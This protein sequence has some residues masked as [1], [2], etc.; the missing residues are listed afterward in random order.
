MHH[1]SLFSLLAPVILVLAGG[2]AVLGAE[3]FLRRADKHA[4]L[5]WIGAI[6]AAI[7]IAVQFA[8]PTGHVHG[9]YAMDPARLWLC[10]S[11]V[12]AGAL[13]L[14]GLQQTLAR[15]DYHGGEPYALTLFATAGAMLMVM[16]SDLL[17]LFVGLEIASLSVYALV[18]LRRQRKESNE[19]LFKYFALGAVFSAVFLY[20]AALIYGA[21]GHTGLGYAPLPERESLWYLGHGLLVLALLF[22]V[23]VVPFHTWSPD[24]YTGAPAAVTGFMGAVIKVG[25]FTALGAVWLHLLAVSG[26]H[27]SATLL[28][29]DQAVNLTQVDPGVARF[30]LVFLVLA[31]VSVIIGNFS[32]LRQSSARRMMAYS[33][34]AHAGYMLFA[35]VLPAA[36][37]DGPVNIHLGGLWFYLV[38]YGLATAGALTAIAALAGKDDAG[39]ELHGLSGQ[40]RA[41]PFH[42]LMLTVFVASFAGIPPTVGFVG[43]F[44]VFS[45]LVVGDHILV[46]VVAMILAVVAAAYY[47]RLLIAVWAPAGREP[48]VAG[49]QLLTGWTTGLAAAAVVALIAIAGTFSA[50]AA[51][52]VAAAAVE[53]TP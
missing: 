27:H 9:L 35:L 40:G 37:T 44:L 12:A 52:P 2:L 36:A 38:G 24:A 7:A 4:W 14:A 21:T 53:A 50:P 1:V 22:K 43:K 29:L 13:G 19:G 15:D 3:P 18:G 31:L 32:A 17:A 49:P 23:G 33:S 6:F 20:G 41:Y 8:V 28:P 26:G 42:G 46:A 45:G 48:A 47:L 30:S 11:V 5:P 34:V 51:S 25:G 16:A 39:D 10:V